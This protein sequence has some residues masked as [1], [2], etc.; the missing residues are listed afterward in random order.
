MI[1]GGGENIFQTLNRPINLRFVL[2][3][4]M[5]N[6]ERH[7]REH[8]SIFTN[9]DVQKRMVTSLHKQKRVT[10]GIYYFDLRTICVCLCSIPWPQRVRLRRCPAYF[11]WL[12]RISRYVAD[13]L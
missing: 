10:L 11:H 1:G 4:Q 6:I 7:F 9:R 2:S 13:N 12:A 8:R 3:F 5:D